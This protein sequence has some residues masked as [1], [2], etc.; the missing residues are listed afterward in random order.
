M[1]KWQSIESIQRGYLG[2]AMVAFGLTAL[3]AQVS[4]F[5]PSVLHILQSARQGVLSLVSAISLS[6]LEPV[7]VLLFHQADYFSLIS[8][9]SRI[10]LL[11]SA[12]AATV[13]GGVLLTA[14]AAAA[15]PD[16]D[17]SSLPIPD[18]GDR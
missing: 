7:R 16:S 8:L 9:I 18:K 1:A 15:T 3:T 2:C 13:I 11:F 5:V 14:R 6:L 12:L 4:A 10:L 17:H